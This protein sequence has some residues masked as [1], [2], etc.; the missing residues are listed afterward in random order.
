MA[1]RTV[2]KRIQWSKEPD[3]APDYSDWKITLAKKCT[4]PTEETP[5]TVTFSVHRSLLG[6]QSE[7]FNRIFKSAD[8]AV[9]NNN[10]GAGDD[11]GAFSE[12][13]NQHSVIDLPPNISDKAFDLFVK[14]FETLLG[15]CYLEDVDFKGTSPVPLFFVCDYFQM[16]DDFESKVY[17]YTENLLKKMASETKL[18]PLYVRGYH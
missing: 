13:K 14:A 11:C 18:H 5:P 2:R 8:S 15:Y 17:D 4:S 1:A 3:E 10:D 7:Y 12:S 9:S 16:E 6:P